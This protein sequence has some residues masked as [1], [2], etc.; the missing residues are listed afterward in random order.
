MNSFVLNVCHSLLHWDLENRGERQLSKIFTKKGT[1][2]KEIRKK[3]E[4]YQ[5]T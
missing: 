1:N 2:K 4:K 3:M 5:G